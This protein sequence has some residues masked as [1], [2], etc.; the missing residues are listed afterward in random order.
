MINNART[1]IL[2][3][4]EGVAGLSSGAPGAELVD[5][6]FAPLILPDRLSK[7][8]SVLLPS[9]FNA[10]QT[11]CT[12]SYIM[13]LLH[14][15]DLESYTLLFDSRYTY[16]LSQD[17]AAQ[18]RD[19]SITTDLMKSSACDLQLIPVY[20]PEYKLAQQGN[21]ITW[22]LKY[23]ASMGQNMT[24]Q[25]N[26]DP[27]QIVT[28]KISNKIAVVNLIA[29]YLAIQITAPSGVLTGSLEYKLTFY[30][31]VEADINKWLIGFTA[32]SAQYGVGSLLFDPWDPYKA[33]CNA[34]QSVWL[35]NNE[36]LLKTGAFI[37]GYVYQCECL[38]RG[39]LTK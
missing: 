39:L 3:K 32:L 17:F 23:D 31:P 1:L 34:L 21:I 12:L 7:V 6:T 37:L 2:N 25:R 18:L 9:N 13:R 26:D 19:S 24:L 28:P 36:S 38:R 33:E 16:D 35:H 5:M 11:N 8:R 20:H 27:L 10:Y 15:P 14:M 4:S 22:T 30:A 29:N